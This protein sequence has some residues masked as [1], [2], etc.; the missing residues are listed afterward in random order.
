M[1][2]TQPLLSK[3][4]IYCL[5]YPV[6]LWHAGE[7]YFCTLW[8]IFFF[9]KLYGIF[10]SL[11]FKTLAVY[12]HLLNNFCQ[13]CFCQFCQGLLIWRNAFLR[14][15]KTVFSSPNIASLPFILEFSFRFWSFS[16]S[17]I[18]FESVF[19]IRL[20]LFDF[21]PY[22]INI[23]YFL[24]GG[25]MN[26]YGKTDHDT[27]IWLIFVL[28]FTKFNSSYYNSGSS[29]SLILWFFFFSKCLRTSINSI[30]TEEGLIDILR[31]S[32]NYNVV[33]L[34]FFIF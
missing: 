23:Y 22:F 18:C 19:L 5:V 28:F 14:L 7:A 2:H 11:K 8:I 4:Y 33:G 1:S 27:L 31:V 30:T 29:I 34:L 3:Y 9:L 26:I 17:L 32:I 21:F 6:T 24:E 12:T 20:F 10:L 13:F 16:F 15:K 25:W